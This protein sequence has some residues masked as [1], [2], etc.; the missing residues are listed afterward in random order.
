[1]DMTGEQL[2][3]APQQ[4]VWIAL[5]DPE[6]LKACVPG[7]ESIEK[8]AENEYEVL[9]TAR[10]GPVSAKFRGKLSLADVHAPDSYSIAFDGQGGAAGF[11]KGSAKVALRTESP[12]ST[13]LSYTVNAHVGGKLAQ[14]G[15]RLVDMAA[16]KVAEDFFAAFNA[17]VGSPTPADDHAQAHEHGGT[18]QDAHAAGHGGPVPRDPDLPSVDEPS[19]AFFA[20]GALLVVAVALLTLL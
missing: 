1:M 17:K 9:M 16:K 3:A 4:K 12:G 5:N 18:H 7:C 2:I 20:A 13:R 10:I 14:I 15:S 8:R 11:G 6:V 19:L